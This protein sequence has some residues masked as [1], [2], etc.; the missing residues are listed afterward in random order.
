MPDQ[1]RTEFILEH[2]GST[3]LVSKV[4]WN[5]TQTMIDAILELDPRTDSSSHC[6]VALITSDAFQSASQN[7]VKICDK[8]LLLNHELIL[9]LNVVIPISG[10]LGNLGEEFLNRLNRMLIAGWFDEFKRE[11]L[12]GTLVETSC[13]ETAK[14]ASESSSV[15]FYRI[16]VPCG[17]SFIFNAIA[18]GVFLHHRRKSENSDDE[19]RTLIKREKS[20]SSCNEFVG[21]GIVG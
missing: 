6:D 10:R 12:N 18:V 21:V 2:P 11:R 14:F 9:S 16:L 4:K 13:D 17:I 5:D 20:E 3:E 7:N 1:L 19:G 15:G 8:L